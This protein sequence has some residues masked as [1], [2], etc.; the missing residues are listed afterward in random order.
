MFLCH[1]EQRNVSVGQIV[2]AG[3]VIGREGSTGLSTGSHV[4]LEMR[5]AGKSTDPTP[6]LGIANR[7]GTYQ[8]DEESNADKVCR[9]CGFEKQTRDYLDKYKYA[10]DLWRKLWEAMK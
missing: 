9:K 6:F 1:L 7:A 8:A 3:D 10:D 2:K 4:H 5:Y